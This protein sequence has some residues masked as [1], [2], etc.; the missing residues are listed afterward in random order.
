MQKGRIMK[1]LLLFGFILIFSS[2]NIKGENERVCTIKCSPLS[3]WQV[4][5]DAPNT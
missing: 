2:M 1:K 3:C 4:C 5:T